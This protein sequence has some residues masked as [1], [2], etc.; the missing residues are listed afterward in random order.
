MSQQ[1]LAERSRLSFGTITRI[2][3]R[4][5]ENPTL[6]TIEALGKGLSMADPLDLLRR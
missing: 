3:Q 5:I 2:E 6:D 1:A 4:V